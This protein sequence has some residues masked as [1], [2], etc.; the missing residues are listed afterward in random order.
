[1]LNISL[2]FRKQFRRKSMPKRVSIKEMEKA[3]DSNVKVYTTEESPSTEGSRIEEVFEDNENWQKD[4]KE[5]AKEI[6]M[7]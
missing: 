7:E 4:S 3:K 2:E 5:N 6:L 1:L